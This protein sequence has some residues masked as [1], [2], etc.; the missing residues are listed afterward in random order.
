MDSP[1]ARRKTLAGVHRR[2]GAGP[3]RRRA[4]CRS[5]FIAAGAHRDLDAGKT[6]M[7]DYIKA[8]VGFE[9]L[10]AARR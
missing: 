5:V 4:A 2:S 7:R 9:K 3:R 6:I 8:T 1:L 10:G